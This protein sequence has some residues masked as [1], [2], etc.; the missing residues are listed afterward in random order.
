MGATLSCLRPSAVPQGQGDA[1]FQAPGFD[2]IPGERDGLLLRE[3]TRA[4]V[5]PGF[6][7]VSD[8]LE[9][10]PPA[11]RPRAGLL[12]ARPGSDGLRAVVAA[13]ADFASRG[14]TEGLI[15]DMMIG[16][17]HLELLPSLGVLLRHGLISFAGLSETVEQSR[18]NLLP[19]KHCTILHCMADADPRLAH[20]PERSSLSE[21]FEVLAR[22]GVDLDVEADNAETPL[23]WAVRTG[24]EATA[25]ALI[26]AGADATKTN[27]QGMAALHIAAGIGNASMVPILARSAQDAGLPVAKGKREGWTALHLAAE[28]GGEGHCDVIGMLGF[29][30]AGV[31]DRN[32]KGDSAL[33]VA[34]AG[35][36]PAAVRA[37]AVAGACVDLRH[38]QQNYTALHHACGQGMRE[39]GVALLE[40]GAN[41]DAM[42]TDGSR[43]LH[44]VGRR[45]PG[46]PGHR[47]DLAK[48]LVAAGANIDQPDRRGVLPLEAAGRQGNDFIY[49]YLDGLDAAGERKLCVPAIYP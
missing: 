16:G 21:R 30:G 31:N 22:N 14:L 2:E 29:C 32:P 34:T 47:V 19:H 11:L 12:V 43:P 9:R 44:L 24:N 33:M 26:A 38:G 7:D 46:M 48:A 37:L 23:M 28:G 13:L 45:L 35:G 5:P 49:N 18:W 27:R 40:S 20:G 39:V 15:R 6:D 4:G 3:S 8:L 42:A 17:A 25:M 10:V 36:K 1:S 41:P